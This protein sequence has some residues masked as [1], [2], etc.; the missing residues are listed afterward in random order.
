MADTKMGKIASG[1]LSMMAETKIYIDLLFVCSYSKVYF[2]EHFKWLQGYDDKACDFVYCSRNMAVRSYFIQKELEEFSTNSAMHGKSWKSKRTPQTWRGERTPK[3]EGEDA[4]GEVED[5]AGEAP[6]AKAEATDAANNASSR[7]YNFTKEDVKN[8][9]KMFFEQAIKSVKKDFD[10]WRK[11]KLL[12]YTFASDP[13]VARL[14]AR[15]RIYGERPISGAKYSSKRLERDGIDLGTLFDY[16][17]ELTTREDIFDSPLVKGHL[18]AITKLADAP[19]TI[20]LTSGRI[21]EMM[22]ILRG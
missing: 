15:W 13:E 9:V 7:L 19:K 22:V 14:V 5:T 1:M 21:L 6:N 16:L 11:A 12:P 4:A 20:V 17:T 3:L 8:D 10:T 2:V 18:P